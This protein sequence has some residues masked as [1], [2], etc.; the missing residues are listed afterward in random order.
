M[1]SLLLDYFLSLF[2]LFIFFYYFLAD[3]VNFPTVLLGAFFTYFFPVSLSIDF[4]FHH[5]LFS[6]IIIFG[7]EQFI[8]LYTPLE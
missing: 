4:V 8:C 5:K 6:D 2:H 7:I 3:I 1:F